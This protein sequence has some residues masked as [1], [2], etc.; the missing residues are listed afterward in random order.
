MNDLDALR[1]AIEDRGRDPEYYAATMRR[2]RAEWPALWA[3]LDA[4]LAPPAPRPE[5]RRVAVVAEHFRIAREYE[6][7]HPE[8][9]V[10]YVDRVEQI[11]GL[12]N[13]PLI[14]SCGFGKRKDLDEIIV[15]AKSHDMPIT[16]VPCSPGCK[17]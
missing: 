7:N 4:L 3:A 8:Q 5:R 2:H 16:V 12:R 6:Q 10:V 13:V 11:M 9:R 14:L 15:E 1:R 17:V